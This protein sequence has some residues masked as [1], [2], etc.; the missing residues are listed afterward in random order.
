MPPRKVKDNY[1]SE[2][3][4]N[5]TELLQVLEA[6]RFWKDPLALHF[7][8]NP[9]NIHLSFDGKNFSLWKHTILNTISYIYKIHNPIILDFLKTIIHND[10]SSSLLILCQK[11]DDSTRHLLS[12]YN[13]TSSLFDALQCQY[14]RS[15][16]LG[17]LE[18]TNKFL[19]ILNSTEHRDT[20]SWLHSLQDIYTKFMS[21]KM[22]FLEFF[23]L[24]VK[25]NIQI[26]ETLNH[27]T[28]NILLHQHLNQQDTIPAF[29]TVLEAI[30]EAET[31][32][33][34]VINPAI[35]DLNAS[36]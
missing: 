18:I 34:V 22:S 6:W 35:I 23:G 15:G 7:S 4:A 16:R 20:G 8:I 17:K 36:A 28:F 10:E 5:A 26:L 31:A 33:T 3:E 32:A 13:T 19:H 2:K 9:K 30:Q 11:I 27:N 21:W 14:D 29:E 24:L 1:S 25:A 12:Y